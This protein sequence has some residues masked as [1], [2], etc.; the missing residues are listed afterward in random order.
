MNSLIHFKGSS[1]R[2]RGTR[3]DPLIGGA[4]ACKLL[5]LRNSRQA[6]SRIPREDIHVITVDTNKGPRKMTFVTESGFYDLV[7][8][9]RKPEAVAFRRWVCKRVLPAIRK[10]GE[11][12]PARDDL[13]ADLPPELLAL[14]SARREH[15][16]LWL[17]IM[18]EIASQKMPHQ[19]IHEIVARHPNT[20]SFSVPSL[21]RRFNAWKDSNGDWKSQRPYRAP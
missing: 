6:L 3:E 21:Y 11:F 18:Q 1:I 7:F 5:G 9:S 8:Q 4:D 12:V 17:D 15:I 14:P 10:H 16:Q 13:P 2:L 20:R 19:K